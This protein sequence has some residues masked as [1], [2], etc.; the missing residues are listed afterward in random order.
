MAGRLALVIGSECQALGLL[1]FTG[2]RAADL[3]DALVRSDAWRPVTDTGP[4]L[5]PDVTGLKAAITGA[6]ATA[7][8][9]RATLLIAFV[10][11]GV[12]AGAEDLYLLARDSPAV[13]DSDTGFHLVQGIRERLTRHQSI[14][15]LVILVDA[16]EAGEGLRGAA[17]RWDALSGGGPTA[18]AALPAGNR[19]HDTG[20]QGSW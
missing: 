13:P 11:H 16:C 5:D 19:Q 18:R 1:G 17:R 10:G 6:F 15:G 4:V 9:A 8:A 12:S 3:H 20:P 14:D 7:D 2:Q